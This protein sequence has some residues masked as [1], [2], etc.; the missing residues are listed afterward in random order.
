MPEVI[1]AATAVRRA[2]ALAAAPGRALLGLA[3]A[4]AA[5]KSTLAARLAEQVT[6][7]V[8]VPMDGFH[9]P[10]AVL[11]EH[12]WVGERGTP[13]TFDADGFV[14]LLHELAAGRALRAPAF[15]RSR[16][17]PVAAAVDVPAAAP[18]LI[19]EGNYLLLDAPPWD[20][21]RTLL[22]AVW[23]VEVDEQLRLARLIARHVS[24]GATPEWATKRATQGSDAANARVVSATRAHADLVVR[25]DER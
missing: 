11:A 1:D 15:D 19:V 7:S 5:G 6:G 24:F 18:L 20:A 9:L 21:V 17:E 12:G 14:A 8:V 22:D 25:A 23:F 2:I 4:P 13:R 10:T 16:E 3:G